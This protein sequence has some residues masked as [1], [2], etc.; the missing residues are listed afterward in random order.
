MPEGWRLLRRL[1]EGKACLVCWSLDDGECERKSALSQCNRVECL[2]T[3]LS[4]EQDRYLYPSLSY[5]CFI[6]KARSWTPAP[7]TAVCLAHRFAIHL[8]HRSEHSSNIEA[9]HERR[10]LFGRGVR[11]DHARSR[12]QSAIVIVAIQLHS[13]WQCQ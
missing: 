8:G 11:M 7:S 1:D 2:M 5:L 12:T 10:L 6:R 13:P 3:T 4:S 9:V